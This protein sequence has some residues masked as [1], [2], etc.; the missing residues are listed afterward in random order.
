M[1]KL[2]TIWMDM[3]TNVFSARKLEGKITVNFLRLFLWLAAEN[4]K[5]KGRY[6]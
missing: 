3:T 1:T 6:R 5:L 4:I 2:Y